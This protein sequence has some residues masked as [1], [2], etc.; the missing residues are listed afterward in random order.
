MFIGRYEELKALKTLF[1]KKTFEFGVIHGRRRVGKTTLIK[2]SIKDRKS[3]Y[4]LA[5]QTNTAT[6][7]EMFSKTYG[8][9]KGVGNIVYN[10]FF[11]LFS[12]IFKEKD[13]IVVIDEF[14]YLIESDK[15]F[16]SMLQGLIDNNK[17][18]SSIKLIISGSEVG[19]FENLFS[20]SRPL[21]NRQTFHLHL[22]E[23]DY[24]ESSEYYKNFNNTDKIRLYAVFGGLPY[25]LSKI[26]DSLSVKENIINLIVNENAQF[27]SEVQML[28]TTELRS[29]LEYQSILQAIHSGSSTLA[30]ISS[31]SNI[32]DTAKTSKYVNKLIN[33]EI[34]EK[35]YRFKD[36][37][38][39]KKYLYKIKNNF[40]AFYY[41]F[42]LK[43]E[44]A[45]MIMEPVDFYEVFIE[46]YLDDYVSSRFE[47]ICSQYLIRNFKNR[48]NKPLINIGRYWYNNRE[49]KEDVEI[50]VCLEDSSGKI[51][52]YECKWTNT[53]VTNKI[54]YNLIEKGKKVNATNYGAFSKNGF[55]NDLYNKSFDLITIDDLFDL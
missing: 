43:N 25:Y 3:L 40:F 14:T 47:T 54:M 8:A 53:L 1:D 30:L 15:S 27:A 29:I 50:D 38:T 12:E 26:D 32:N 37:P 16:E 33:L 55:S 17:D 51:Y 44:S 31:K 7:L 5:Q 9:Y 34:I 48:N 4:F 23:C 39:S 11:E 42:I 41:R 19:M 24:Y 22:K 45:R 21:F 52:I 20:V 18:T 13:L 2:E 49:L 36:S 6:N 28:L 46:K 35:E 10:S